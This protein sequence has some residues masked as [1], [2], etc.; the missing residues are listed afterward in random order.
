MPVSVPTRKLRR[1]LRKYAA[2]LRK[3][4]FGLIDVLEFNERDAHSGRFTSRRDQPRTPGRRG[5]HS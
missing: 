4:D 1:L 3:L 5:T 2:T